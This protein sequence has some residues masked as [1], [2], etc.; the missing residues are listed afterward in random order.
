MKDDTTLINKV[1]EQI[2]NKYMAVIVGSKRARAVNDE[3]VRPL[4]KTSA[5]KPTTIALE[6]ISAGAIVP[7]PAMPEIEAPKETE[8]ELLPSPDSS[9]EEEE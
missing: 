4:V 2:P 3:T 6:E 5:T 1:L 7:G 8:E 9:E